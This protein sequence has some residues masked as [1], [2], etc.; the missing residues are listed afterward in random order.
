MKRAVIIFIILLI[1]G[2][3]AL[4]FF[5][6]TSSSPLA[7]TINNVLPFGS[8][9]DSVPG[10]PDSTPS[11]T[12]TGGGGSGS[13]SHLFKI[14]DTPVAGAIALV[15][16]GTMVV[17]YVERATG[18]IYDVDP[19]NLIKTEIVN[20]TVPKV[21]E[22]L[23]KPSGDTV[24]LR[25]LRSDG[26]TIDS[27]SVALIPP[28]GT[29]TT[30]TYTT[31]TTGLQANIKDLAT[32]STTIFYSLKGLPQITTASFDGSKAATIFSSSFNQWKL[33]GGGD[34]SLLLTTKASASADGYSYAL[35]SKTGE[36]QKI[37]GPL[38]GLAVTANK[39]LT[40]IAYSY[41][42]NGLTHFSALNLLN[43]AQFNILPVTLAEKCVWSTRFPSVLYCGIPL[44][45]IA[46]G[47]PDAWYK[48]I[49][50]YADRLWK[51]NVDVDFA[52]II[53]DPKKEFNVDID[54]EN[55]FLSPNEDYLFLENKNDL[56]LWA[57]KLE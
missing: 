44:Q 28:T 15:K 4:Y 14:S 33:I 1:L 19:A 45:G 13:R 47:E 31:K 43:G 20:S 37:L 32:G 39:N 5:S 55:L 24:I 2:I 18:H 46:D 54:A 23:F 9:G 12:D 25:T 49:S 50:H 26:E 42:E 51:F 36:S 16:N 10:T 21:Y 11:S 34:T 7:Q 6:R 57:L 56:T 41:S 38:V 29:S 53:T 27:T 8:G 3:T 40:R 52:N 30:D 22:A 48:G 35:K 17:R